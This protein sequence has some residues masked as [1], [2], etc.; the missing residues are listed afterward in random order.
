MSLRFRIAATIFVLEIFLILGVL[1]VTSRHTLETSQAQFIATNA[2]LTSL[3]DDLSRVALLT[4][5]YGEL[6]SFIEESGAS[7][8]AAIALVDLGGRV[9]A[10]D[11]PGRIGN[12][13]EP[14]PLDGREQRQLVEIGQHGV[15]L[16]T[17]SVVFSDAELI[18]ASQRAFRLGLG[19]AVVGM[20]VIAVVGLTMGHLLTRRLSRLALVA[21]RVAAGETTLRTRLKGRDE[22]ARVGFAMDG[23]LDRLEGHLRDVTLD[24]DRLAQPTEAMSDGLAIWDA[25]DRLVRCNRRLRELLAALPLV[26][27]PGLAHADL[28]RAMAEHLVHDGELDADEWVRQAHARRRQGRSDTEL[29]L[30]HGSWLR[31]AEWPM[32]DGG[33]AAIYTDI[34]EAKQ[35]E[36]ATLES[37]ERL[38]V[39]TDSV[40]EGIAMLDGDGQIES[41]NR[42]MQT[43]LERPAA[44]LVGSRFEELVACPPGEEADVPFAVAFAQSAPDAIKRIE[45]VAQ[46]P[47][48]PFP[49]E[50]GLRRV[51][52]RGQSSCIVT[53]RDITKQHRAHATM[54]HQAT[55]DMLTGLPNRVLFDDR[56]DQAIA[57]AGRHDRRVALMLLDLDR[58]KAVNDTLGHA[59]GDDLLIAVAQRLRARVRA[60]DTVAR[61]AGDEF[62]V[63]LPDL[64]EIK[65]AELPAKKLLETLRLPVRVQGQ[66]LP[67]SASIGIAVFPDHGH[68]RPELLKRADMALY[69]AKSRGRNGFAVFDPAMIE[70]ASERA[71]LEADLRQSLARGELRLVYQPQ[72]DIATGRPVGLEALLRWTH[73]ERGA[74]PPASFVPLAEE[75]GLIGSLGAWVLQRAC[76]DF[77]TW[78][79]MRVPITRLAVNVSP[80]Q[81][82]DSLLDQ[83]QQSLGACAIDPK[84]LELE[85]T[86]TALLLDQVTATA[87]MQELRA[88]GIGLALDDFGTG[89]SSLSNLRHYPVQRLKIDRS[90]IRSITSDR[91]DAALSRAVIELARGL[92]MR[93][94]A[95]GIETEAQL[96]LL[97]QF[98][99]DEGQGFYL[100]RPQDSA[101]VPALFATAAG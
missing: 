39:I 14:I 48:G 42:A 79:Q 40:G 68:D 38:R 51:T 50:V 9:V 62:V 52:W 26:L 71:L 96:G 44:E 66:S 23:M 4:D 92:S 13:F 49:V 60:S 73:P 32:V 67:I 75:S 69:R 20:V 72:F 77:A 81:L 30:R 91:G 63:V 18:A 25:G 57:A 56:L 89:Y 80:R 28:T 29:E 64:A 78:R 93:V 41:V 36:K 74:I 8:L 3:L 12:P 15:R 97:R 33:F 45:L 90:F 27:R 61:M 54:L 86:E 76:L 11:D 37:E 65:D 70:Q 83:V 19:A 1:F 10:S 24:R 84:S 34:T 2:S 5:D 59:A 47:S 6:Q 95:E 85:L 58:F 35:R 46:R 55:H 53:L 101:Q 7:R 88:L 17:L 98:G 31:V 100:G 87:T 22:V 43:L 21:D 16:G 82:N 99:C 94:V